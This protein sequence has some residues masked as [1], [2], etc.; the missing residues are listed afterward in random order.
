MTAPYDGIEKY[1]FEHNILEYIPSLALR[2]R[3]WSAGW[4]SAQRIKIPMIAGDN[5]TIN[6]YDP[7]LQN[8]FS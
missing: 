4:C 1:G 5:H 6:L 2:N 3:T 7:A 8:S